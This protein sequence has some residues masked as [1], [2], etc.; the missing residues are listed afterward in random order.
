[1]KSPRKQNQRERRA[2]KE[3]TQE[4]NPQVSNQIVGIPEAIYKLEGKK[5]IYMSVQDSNHARKI[6]LAES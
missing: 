5:Y 6:S 3:E 2:I 4:L 1:M